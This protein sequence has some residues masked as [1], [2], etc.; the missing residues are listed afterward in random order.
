MVFVMA[1]S[2]GMCNGG[3]R[4]KV[5]LRVSDRGWPSNGGSSGLEASRL[6]GRGSSSDR[7]GI[8]YSNNLIA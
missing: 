7:A 4:G 1:S 2:Q 8:V 6:D 3:S 5:E